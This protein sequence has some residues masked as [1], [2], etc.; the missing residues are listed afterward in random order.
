MSDSDV[1]S[2]SSD[3]SYQRTTEDEDSD[4]D[5]IFCVNDVVEAS[6]IDIRKYLII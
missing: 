3:C 6:G 1:E 2:V 5:N 4:H